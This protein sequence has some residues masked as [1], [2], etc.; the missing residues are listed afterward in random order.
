ML[1]VV[2]IQRVRTS[3][4]RYE[5]PGSAPELLQTPSEKFRTG[6]FLVVIDS[7]DAELRKRLN[8]Y[9]NIAGRFGFLRKLADLSNEEVI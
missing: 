1:A 7:L 3:N 5:E 2:L 8:A 6:T 9:A 4:R